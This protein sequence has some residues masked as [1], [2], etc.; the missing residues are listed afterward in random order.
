MTGGIISLRGGFLGYARCREPASRDFWTTK[1]PC[2]CKD[3]KKDTNRKSTKA[4]HC[5]TSQTTIANVTQL[6]H[7]PDQLSQRHPTQLELS[8]SLHP[9]QKSHSFHVCPHPTSIDDSMAKLLGQ[10][11]STR[12]LEIGVENLVAGRHIIITLVSPL[13]T[14][15]SIGRACAEMHLHRI[16][17]PLPDKFACA[18][19]IAPITCF[20]SRPN[21]AEW[22][23]TVVPRDGEQAG[24]ARHTC[25]SKAYHT[26]YAQKDH[27]VPM[28]AGQQGP[29]SAASVVP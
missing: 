17:L 16:R 2:V 12:H 29:I 20:L 7:L 3:A 26:V 21:L 14:I 9:R 6:P 13:S 10:C 24:A 22:V 23:P 27:C 5:P 15:G 1:V 18:K 28:G 8:E 11:K 19:K 25:R 4:Q